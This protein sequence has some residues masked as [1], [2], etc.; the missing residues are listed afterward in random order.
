MPQKKHLKSSKVQSPWFSPNR[1]PVGFF[2]KVPPTKF[3]LEDGTAE[4]EAQAELPVNDQPEPEGM[5]KNHHESRS[6]SEGN[7]GKTM[8]FSTS[9]C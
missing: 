6:F 1:P 4:P 3:D 7:H 8:G 2:P 9:N 5:W